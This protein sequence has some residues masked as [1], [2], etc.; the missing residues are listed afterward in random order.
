M[1]F[2][3]VCLWKIL[4]YASLWLSFSQIVFPPLQ[5]LYTTMHA[6]IHTHTHYMT[7][8]CTRVSA[9]MTGSSINVSICMKKTSQHSCTGLYLFWGWVSGGSGGVGCGWKWKRAGLRPN[10]C[11]NHLYS[12]PSK[13]V[14]GSTNVQWIKVFWPAANPLWYRLGQVLHH[15]YMSMWAKENVKTCMVHM[16]ICNTNKVCTKHYPKLWNNQCLQNN[17]CSWFG[18]WK[19]H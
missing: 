1:S 12:S 5:E 19:G 18:D 4:W 13:R 15:L 6:G 17:T 16:M 3:F 9:C 11:L 2:P 8:V 7:A 14:R 10:P